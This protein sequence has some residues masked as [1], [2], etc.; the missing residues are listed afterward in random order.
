MPPNAASVYLLQERG[1][2]K[3]EPFLP[4]PVVEDYNDGKKEEQEEKIRRE[5]LHGYFGDN[6]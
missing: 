1:H 2:T 5:E 4:A 6:Y 3:I